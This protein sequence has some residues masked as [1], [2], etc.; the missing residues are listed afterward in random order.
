MCCDV[1]DS[2]ECPARCPFK[3]LTTT[4]R[5]WES[6]QYSEAQVISGWSEWW[7][8]CMKGEHPKALPAINT[9]HLFSYSFD[10][11]VFYVRWLMY[12]QHTS[13]SYG[14]FLK[15]SGPNNF[16]K[17][18]SGKLWVQTMKIYTCLLCIDLYSLW[19]QSIYSYM[20]ISPTEHTGTY[21]CAKGTWHPL[22]SEFEDYDCRRCIASFQDIQQQTFFL[23]SSKIIWKLVSSL[24]VLRLCVDQT[25]PTLDWMDLKQA[26]WW[27]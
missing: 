3:L 4:T 25:I 2:M 17:G 16:L 6:L 23:Y 8:R 20:G 11:A 13:F 12:S 27:K 19:L 21:F 14:H 24:I 22:T 1:K 5:L 9:Q 26:Q 7:G 10:N 18:A 15:T